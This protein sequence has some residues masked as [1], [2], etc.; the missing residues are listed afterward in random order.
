[1]NISLLQQS[2]RAAASK[3]HNLMRSASSIFQ[4]VILLTLL[5][6]NFCFAAQDEE[7]SKS[8]FGVITA[9]HGYVVDEDDEILETLDALSVVDIEQVNDP[10]LFV[11]TAAGT[12]GWIRTEQLHRSSLFPQITSENES[13]IR[14][15]LE[16]AKIAVA[17]STNGENATVIEQMDAALQ[18]FETKVGKDNTG[19]AW[20]LAYHSAIQIE[21]GEEEAA[22]ETLKQAEQILRSL[23]ALDSL[24]AADVFNAKAILAQTQGNSDAA[25]HDYQSALRIIRSHLSANHSDVR[26][27]SSNLASAYDESGKPKLAIPH[28]RRAKEIGAIILPADVVERVDDCRNL[29][30]YLF[31]SEEYKDARGE[32]LEA[33]LMLEANETFSLT[34]T[35]EV[36]LD[37]SEN[38]YQTSDPAMARERLNEIVAVL[39]IGSTGD[40]DAFDSASN[41]L[42]ARTSKLLGLVE[43]SVS[44]HAVALGHFEESLSFVD[45]TAPDASDADTATEAGNMAAKLERYGAARRFYQKSLSMYE[46]L[47]ATKSDA[48]VQVQTLLAELPKDDGTPTPQDDSTDVAHVLVTAPHG[49]LTDESGKLVR[50]IR[51][52]SYLEVVGETETSF[53]VRDQKSEL[54]IRKELVRRWQDVAFLWRHVRTGG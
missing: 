31:N 27:L 42:H 50:T 12:K 24:H 40:D 44:R 6:A 9:Q 23:K 14:K 46:I 53:R 16:Q 54:F 41:R 17:T 33:K 47:E 5:A 3:V 48:A 11:S 52:F 7:A 13:A 34:G 26:V 28:Q 35:L 51:Y 20:L 15:S 2:F 19:Y 4:V 36:M 25:I 45:E 8:E 22:G 18:T 30:A 32:L 21:Q 1:M 38:Y 43:S 10:W 29:A 37:L 39:A 49:Y